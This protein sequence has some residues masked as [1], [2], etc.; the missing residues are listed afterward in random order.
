[1]ATEISAKIVKELRD[2]TS[3]GM[4]DCKKALQEADGDFAKAEEALKKKGLANADKKS[5]R[6]AT[7]GI[8]EAYIHMGGK[9]GVLV[10]VNCETDFVARRPE[11]QELARN[12]AMQIAACPQVEYI[13]IADIPPEVAEEEKKVE[14]GK[15]DLGN[16][17]VEIKEKIVEGRIQKKLKEKA[18]L[19]QVFIRDTSMTIEELVKKNIAE[20]GE[21][22]QIRRFE[23]FNLGEGLEKK[24]ENFSD[25]VEKMKKR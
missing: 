11:F 2:K 3:A 7:E 8:V 15:D 23:K 18:L 13:N 5:D 14:M 17:P 25:E 20:M 9:L 10:E 16:K 6:I 22:I 21:N 4:M 12:V 1:M 24:D 19:D